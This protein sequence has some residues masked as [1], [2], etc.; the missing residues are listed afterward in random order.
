[1][2]NTKT[3]T[4]DFI[5]SFLLYS[6]PSYKR[7]PTDIFNFNYQIERNTQR[8]VIRLLVEYNNKD[9]GI[10][11]LTIPGLKDIC[12]SYSL[13]VSRRKDELIIRITTHVEVL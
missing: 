13:P 8:R 4:T 6:H 3:N 9:Q 5:I 7:D 2:N 1:M 11:A 10:L 12:H